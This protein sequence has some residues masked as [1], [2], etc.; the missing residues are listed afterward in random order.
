M[1]SSKLI[2]FIGIASFVIMSTN[3]A[4]IGTP[5]E[6]CVCTREFVPLCGSD[7]ITYDNI[8][9]F[10]CERQRNK[11]LEIQSDDACNGEDMPKD[12]FCS[13]SREFRPVCSTHNKTYNNEC[14]LNCKKADFAYFGVCTDLQATTPN[15]A[16]DEAS[17]LSTFIADSEKSICICAEIDEPVCG[18]NG[19]TYSNKCE[20]DCA[21]E[22]EETLQIQYDGKCGKPQTGECKCAVHALF[23]AFTIRGRTYAVI[24]TVDSE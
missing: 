24:Q 22:T 14:M 9:V 4:S 8:C 3:A 7:N 19:K 17:T 18:S 16:E 12:E 23:Y 10:E 13:C 6:S 5:N 21:K 1:G 15:S 2:V 11:L 20:F